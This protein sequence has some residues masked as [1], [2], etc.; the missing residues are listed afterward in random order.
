MGPPPIPAYKYEPPIQAP[1]SIDWSPPK[2]TIGQNL[3][4]KQQ[5]LD[6]NSYPGEIT[7]RSILGSGSGGPRLVYC[8]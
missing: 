8:L 2:R 3:K 1:G 7:F 5:Q 4:G 6:S